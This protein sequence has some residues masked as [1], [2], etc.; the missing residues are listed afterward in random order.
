MFADGKIGGVL[1]D[2]DQTLVD[3]KIASEYR[4]AGRWTKVKELVPKF[5]VYDGVKHMWRSLRAAKMRIAIV[6]A[7]PST[8]AEKVIS[9]FGFE[10]DA[11]VA[12]H[13]TKTHKPHPEPYSKALN[14]LEVNR[15]S[16]WAVGD[17][18]ID[19]VAANSL[20]IVSVGATWGAEDL[21]SLIGA[22]P[23]LVF[24]DPV[25]LGNYFFPSQQPEDRG[26]VRDLSI[27]LFGI[28]PEGGPAR[29]QKSNWFCVGETVVSC[30]I[31]SSLLYGFR[32][33]YSSGGFEYHYWALVCPNC[34][35]A[36]EPKEL[37]D[38]SRKALYKSSN[39]TPTG[40]R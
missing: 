26:S 8:Y 17:R 33:P 31:C 39:Y 32:A 22:D 15:A 13:D 12:Y 7:A 9:Q 40:S 29:F 14:R 35:T 27:A 2:L 37:G 28:D 19:V 11:V 16:A 24:D 6:T 20:G 10:P 34:R 30:Q 36:M 3:S 4:D 1:I 18:S 21:R 23:D 38:E 5:K 25:A